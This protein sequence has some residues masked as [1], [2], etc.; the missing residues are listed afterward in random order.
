MTTK[1]HPLSIPYRSV[2]TALGLLWIVFLI[3]FSGTAVIGG[4]T[5]ALVFGAAILTGLVGAVVWEILYYQRFEYELTEDTFDLA[6]GVVSRRNREIP[7]R[8]IQNVGISRNVIQ[9]LAGI[10]EV[11]FET[12]GGSGAE[13]Q[14][15]YVSYEEAQRLQDELS[16]RK[17]RRATT[18]Q[19]GTQSETEDGVPREPETD[20][21]F[22]ITDW[23]LV[24]LGVVSIDLRLIPLLT[25]AIPFLSPALADPALW[26]GPLYVVAPLAAIVLYLLTS[27]AS[28]IISVT[29]YYG[30]LLVRTGDELRFERGL[31]QRY[32]GTIPLSKVQ[33]LTI[34][35]NVLERA[36]GYASLLIETAGYSPGESGGSQSAV[37][38]AKRGRVLDLAHSI[39]PYGDVEFERPP[40]RA[41]ER[42]FFRYLGVLA[43]LTGIV[44]LVEQYYVPGLEW[45][46]MLLGLIAVP[47]GAHLK[48][49]HLGYALVDDHIVTRA[50]FW[51]RKTTVVPYHRVQTVLDSQTIFQR[52]RKLATL[53]VDTAGSSSLIGQDARAIDI[54]RERANELR[55][56]VADR[57]QESL[58]GRTAPEDRLFDPELTGT[59]TEEGTPS[60]SPGE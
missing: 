4:T 9:R 59:E 47:I 28:G 57:L 44:Y 24:V 45:Y 14:L 56:D 39:E 11:S 29:N 13:A 19:N 18:D 58:A 49:K 25:L 8:R 20:R 38:I 26:A 10:A 3:G 22:E 40:K 60:V 41:R 42:Y 35:E 54:D 2:Q 52:R 15:R 7:Y 16:E 51:N 27:I 1:L 17:R 33:T 23:E 21:L 12:A 43:V 53:T 5:G 30:F 46:W 36:V 55:E 6:S 37:P 31:L 32:S 48:W 34:S 50:G